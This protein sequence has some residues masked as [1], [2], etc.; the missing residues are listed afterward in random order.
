MKKILVAI[1]F[2][3]I[4][5]ELSCQTLINHVISSSGLNSSDGG[6]SITW[7]SGEPFVEELST[8]DY[9]LQQGFHQSKLTVLSSLDMLPD[10]FRIMVYPNPV[11]NLLV[12]ELDEFILNH[13]WNINIFNADGKAIFKQSLKSC[14]TEFDFSDYPSAVYLLNV[15]NE[16]G[17]SKVF[18]ISKQ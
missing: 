4:T 12:I 8:P 7:T 16:I 3:L 17:K 9:I 11:G 10:N 18:T 5:F 6:V 13:N 2:A 15:C 14:I 1:L